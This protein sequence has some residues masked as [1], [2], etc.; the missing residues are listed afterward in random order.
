[1]LATILILLVVS[2]A[3]SAQK[4]IEPLFRPDSI[5][6]YKSGSAPKQL[7]SIMDQYPSQ[8]PI[9]IGGHGMQKTEINSNLLSG[10]AGMAGMGKCIV[11]IN[12]EKAN[13]NLIDG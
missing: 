8:L 9:G 2:D 5:K 11:Y 13:Y 7:N 3:I 6:P 12:V 4:T 10:H 1:M